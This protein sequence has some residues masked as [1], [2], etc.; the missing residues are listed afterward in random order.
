MLAIWI[1][2]LVTVSLIGLI[3]LFGAMAVGF[4]DRDPDEI[5]EYMYY[6]IALAIGALIGDA[7]IHLL[8]EAYATIGRITSLYAILGFAIFFLLDRVL[9][10]RHHHRAKVQDQI[11]AVGVISLV[12]DSLHNFIDGVAIAASYLISFPIGLATSLAVILHEI[13]A[14]LGHYAVLRSAGFT[15][16]SAIWLNFLTAL[17]AI[18]GTVLVLAVRINLGSTDQAILAFTAGGFFY[19]AILLLRKLGEELTAVRALTQLFFI[20]LGVGI[21]WLLV[22]FGS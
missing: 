21:M 11:E 13:P 4:K 20:L 9:H 10:W 17:I 7:V 1:Y 14:E 18:V 5:P 16:K 19:M 3:S 2:S 15:K 12:A 6:L 8:P 22:L